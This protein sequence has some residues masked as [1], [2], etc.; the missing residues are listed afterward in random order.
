LTCR[1]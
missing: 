1:R